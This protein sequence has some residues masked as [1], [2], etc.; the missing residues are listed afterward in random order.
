[1]FRTLD[2]GADGRAVVHHGPERV[3]VPSE[4][5]V[6]WIDLQGQDATSLATL[7]AAFGFHPLAL[8]DCAHFDQR[9]K[10]EE[11]GDHLFLVTHG[12]AVAADGGLEPLELHSFL[13]PRYL[14][15][16]HSSPIAAL[17]TI[18]DRLVSD[19]CPPR[20][21]PD[22]LF[23]L[24]AD[25]LVDALFPLLDRFGDELETHEEQLLS[26][27]PPRHA[28]ADLLQLKRRLVVLRKFLGPQRDVFSTLAKHNTRQV[29]E[30][31]AVYF[32]DVHDHLLRIT[33]SI[34][35]TR[36]LLGNAL[37]A[38]LWTTSQ[39]TN[40]IVKRL[41]ILSA[42]FLPLTF[43]TGFFGQ[44]FTGLP[45]DSDAVLTAVVATCL[46]LPALMLYYFLT[47]RWF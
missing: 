15:T 6:R 42:V 38:Y 2:L 26:G 39:R 36:D 44:N 34:D 1:M 21:G 10:L 8:E 35:A 20:N 17:D 45:F 23:H 41:T 4:G 28:L 40:E 12:F 30:R 33:E 13:G 16:V 31:A 22:F 14:V 47:R 46:G 7:G 25:S 24:V 18:W 32:R 9:A 11:Y 19:G 5:V 27:R 43:L 29:S 37:D 3:A